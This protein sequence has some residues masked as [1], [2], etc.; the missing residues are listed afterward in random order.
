[1][2]LPASVNLMPDAPVAQLVELATLAEGLGYRGCWVYD[3]GLQT[4]DVYVTL[5]AIAEHTGTVGL[6]PGITNPYVRH[7]G[8]T[9]AAVA[10]L[11]ELSGGRAVVGLG[12]GGAMTLGPLGITRDRP[13]TAVREMVQALRRLFAGEVVDHQGHAFSLRG[14]RIGYARPDTEIVLAGR[15][16]RMTA[17]GGEVADGFSL[18][19]IHKALL[20]EHARALRAAA[21]DRRFRIGYSTM[22]V[23][24]DAEADEARA[25]LSFRLVDSPPDVRARIGMTEADVHAVREALASG[26]P[27]QAA[28]HVRDGWL[29]PFVIAGTPAECGVELQRLMRENS[30]DE[31][32]LPLL[33]ASGAG[34]LIERTA[35]M[36]APTDT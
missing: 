23:T 26:G 6:G 30:I 3:E 36:L 17:L 20:G 27:H 35:S 33:G 1:M 21:G 28:R 18:S 4:R 14:A 2:S 32:Q 9:A 19:Y 16:R 25:Q 5:T 22:V 29:E 15:G 11:D 24:S 31:F 8:A 13:V 10:T 34:E 7:P 12:A